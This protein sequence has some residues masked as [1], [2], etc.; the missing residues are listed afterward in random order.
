M[1]LQ[2]FGAKV[3]FRL[4]AC[5]LCLQCMQAIFLLIGGIQVCMACPCFRAGRARVVPGHWAL[6]NGGYPQGVGG[7]RLCLVAGPL[8]MAVTSR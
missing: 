7:C 8:A 5:C 1:G 4:N 2:F 6:G 3:A